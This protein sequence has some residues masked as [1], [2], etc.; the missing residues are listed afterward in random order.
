MSMS[1]STSTPH[2]DMQHRPRHFGAALEDALNPEG[3]RARNTAQNAPDGL[4]GTRAD[5]PL[6][7]VFAPRINI[8]DTHDFASDGWIADA[9]TRTALCS[10]AAY[11]DSRLLSLALTPSSQASSNS[12]SASYPSRVLTTQIQHPTLH[13][14]FSDSPNPARPPPD[15]HSHPR[16]STPTSLARKYVMCGRTP[17]P[18]P[19][20]CTVHTYPPTHWTSMRR[21]GATQYEAARESNCPAPHDLTLEFRFSA[22]SLL[23]A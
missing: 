5:A 3:C 2:H 7:L 11:T 18:R 8:P 21:S 14:P 9:A 15:I 19:A 13:L 23:L 6:R 20:G 10:N 16:T 4:R 12:R 1:M 17:G 22:G